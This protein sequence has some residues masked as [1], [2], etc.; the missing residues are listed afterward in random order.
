MTALVAAETAVLVVLAVLVAGLLRSHASILRRLHE[1]DQAG[2]GQPGDGDVRPPINTFPGVPEPVP[3]NRPESDAFDVSGRTL[4]GEAVVVSTTNVAHDT[5]LAFLSSGCTTCQ[6][7]WEAFATPGQV[8][9]PRD[10]RLVV[11]VKDPGEESPAALSPL[12]PAG[13]DVV[14]SSQ[15]WV[16]YQVPGSPYVVAVEGRSGRVKGQ[17]TG[18]SWDQMARLLAQATGDVAFLADTGQ[19][20]AK[21]LSDAQRE[22]RVD[23]EL[24]AAGILPGDPSLFQPPTPPEDGTAN[25]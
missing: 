19:R 13:L 12:R 16:D 14:M 6:N 1:L 22:S 2:V 7:F 18:L 15:A 11:V 24:M 9:L 20:A 10:T 3:V 23:A 4:D 25:Q 5:V 8:R 21:P 17:G